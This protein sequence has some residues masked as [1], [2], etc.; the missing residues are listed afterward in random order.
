[1]A[2][3]DIERRGPLP[4]SGC[5]EL[6]FGDGRRFVARA[7]SIAAVIECLHGETNAI[8]TMPDG[9]KLVRETMD[10]VLLRMRNA[11]PDTKIVIR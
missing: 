8:V 10:V 4:P 1:M 6:T 9:N 7:T 2:T 3:P 11:G 5:I